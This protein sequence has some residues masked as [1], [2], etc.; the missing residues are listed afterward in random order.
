[1][2][3]E[4]RSRSIGKDET[5][6][7]CRISLFVSASDPRADGSQRILVGGNKPDGSI[8]QDRGRISALV[9]RKGA[10]AARAGTTDELRM[11]S[12]PIDKKRHVVMSKKLGG[13]RGGEQFEVS[14][15]LRTTISHLPYTV[16]TT[17]QLVL[18]RSPRAV[19]PDRHTHRIAL[20]GGEIDES[21]GFNCVLPAASCT[22]RKGG[23]MRVSHSARRLYVNLVLLSG[24]KRA[25]AHAGDAARL[26]PGELT[27]RR[28]APPE[29]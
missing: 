29:K 16:R 10:P 12:S 17:S 23:V 15:R 22:I 8:P 6:E 9:L 2:V 28:W 27:V 19:E 11:K 20:L 14:A 25:T 13:L 7:Q 5:C 26:G 3:I 24:P 21:N 4:P 1:L 18:A